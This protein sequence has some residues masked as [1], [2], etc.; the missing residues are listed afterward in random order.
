[1]V[2]RWS[3]EVVY[4]FWLK[5]KFLACAGN[6]TPVSQRA[7]SSPNHHTACAVL[8]PIPIPSIYVKWS[9]HLLDLWLWSFSCGTN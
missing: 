5:D 3:L 2:V 4:M 7:I 8:L 9:L 6:R 1:M